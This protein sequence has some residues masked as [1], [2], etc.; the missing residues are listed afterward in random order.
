MYYANRT[1]AL[2]LWMQHFPMVPFNRPSRTFHLITV[3]YN[4]SLLKLVCHGSTIHY[5]PCTMVWCTYI[6]DCA[7]CSLVRCHSAMQHSTWTLVQC[8]PTK[9]IAP[10]FFSLP[11]CTMHRA[12][13][14]SAR[15][16]CSVGLVMVHFHLALC[17]KQIGLEHFHY[18]HN[19][20]TVHLVLCTLLRF[21]TTM[22]CW[23]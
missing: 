11:P 18:G 21:T 1:G 16:L 22:H 3:Y 4:Y 15:A 9:H 10:W 20:S 12:A 8:T 19:N 6:M 5:F 13:W 17:T 2:P 7:P 23:N 14:Y